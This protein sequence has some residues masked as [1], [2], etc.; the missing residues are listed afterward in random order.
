M[1]LCLCTT[2]LLMTGNNCAFLIKSEYGHGHPHYRRGE[3]EGQDGVWMSSTNMKEFC[4]ATLRNRSYLSSAIHGQGH[5]FFLNPWHFCGLNESMCVSVLGATYMSAARHG[6]SFHPCLLCAPVL[7]CTMAHR[8]C[9]VYWYLL[10]FC[11][12]F[13][14]NYF[15]AFQAWEGVARAQNFA[16]SGCSVHLAGVLR[17]G[18]KRKT[19]PERQLPGV[20]GELNYNL[21]Q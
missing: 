7:C 13:V 10:S 2:F 5:F 17:G 11:T 1:Y 20:R 6:P 15:F 3:E 16:H 21:S 9:P 8:V 19:L 12:F 4:T 14:H 18:K